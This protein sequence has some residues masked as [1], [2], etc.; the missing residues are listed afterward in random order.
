[1]TQDPALSEIG[2]LVGD[3]SR[4]NILSTLIDGRALTATE[5]A[6]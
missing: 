4:A 6:W 1:M 5:L 2:A 3:P